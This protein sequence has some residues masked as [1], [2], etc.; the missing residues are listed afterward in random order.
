MDCSQRSMVLIER[1]NMTELKP[2]PFCGG[3]A[4]KMTYANSRPNAPVANYKTVICCDR[5]NTSVTDTV[6]VENKTVAES[7]QKMANKWNRRAE[8]G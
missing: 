2:C 7:I 4:R 6:Y 8:H 5:C 1:G 3:E